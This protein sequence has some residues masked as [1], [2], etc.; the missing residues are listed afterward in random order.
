M[1]EVTLEMRI[2]GF[3]FEL[4]AIGFVVT[5]VVSIAKIFM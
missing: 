5:A 3:M 4:A 2:G 1:K